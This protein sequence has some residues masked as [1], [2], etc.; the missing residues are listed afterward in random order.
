MHKPGWFAP[1]EVERV[2]DYLGMTVAEL[3]LSKL[4]VDWWEE[5]SDVLETFVLAPTVVGGNPGD[6][7]DADPRGVCVFYRDGLCTIHEVKPLECREYVHTD[8]SLGVEMRHEHVAK[9]WYSHQDQIR[10]LLGREPEIAGDFSIINM[11]GL[12]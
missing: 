6:M 9:L 3:F 4:S 12:R 8:S 2:A 7:Y 5:T 11:L 1:G 10:Q